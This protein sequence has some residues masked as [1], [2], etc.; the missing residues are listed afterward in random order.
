MTDVYLKSTQVTAETSAPI[1]L[2]PEDPAA[3]FAEGGDIFI[4]ADDGVINPSIQTSHFFSAEL[5]AELTNIFGDHPRP[6]DQLV[7]EILDSPSTELQPTHFRIIHSVAGGV[8]IDGAFPESLGAGFEE[9]RF[10]VLRECTTSL[11]TPLIVYK[12]G[13]DLIVK[14][15]SMSVYSPSGYKFSANPD[16]ATLFLSIDSYDDNQG[17]YRITGMNLNNLILDKAIQ[18]SATGVPYRIYSKQGTGL[19]FPMVRVKGV[20]LSDGDVAGITVPYRH[21]V[22]VV[23]SDFTG[24]NDDP[25]TQATFGVDG[26]ILSSEAVDL[27]ADDTLDT[28]PETETNLVY[29]ACFTLENE[30][31]LAEYGVALYDVLRLD[32]MDEDLRFWFVEGVVDGLY[33]V[34]TWA[35]YE[36]SLF[37]VTGFT[38]VQTVQDIDLTNVIAEGDVFMLGDDPSRGAFRVSSVVYYSVPGHSVITIS[39][40]CLLY[41]S[42]AA[43]E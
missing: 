29:R 31:N 42:D 28:D 43:D 12:K 40:T 1:F 35:D 11:R 34:D 23:S 22:D 25:M 7:L 4:Q 24:L 33:P 39:E 21:P 36:D 16:T 13:T 6:L 20:E 41:T 3:T 15:N 37:N 10:R 2:Q 17:E 19:T 32:N 9:V 5:S 38:T 8:K 30:I 14:E 27:N 26:G 18:E